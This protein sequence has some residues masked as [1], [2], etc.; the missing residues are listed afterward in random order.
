MANKRK[1]PKQHPNIDAM[2]QGMGNMQ[3]MAQPKPMMHNTTADMKA[4]MGKQMPM[5]NPKAK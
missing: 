1:H 2:R 4:A 5:M 3:P